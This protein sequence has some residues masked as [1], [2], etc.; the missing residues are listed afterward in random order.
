MS[1]VHVVVALGLLCTLPVLRSWLREKRERAAVGRVFRYGRLLTPELKEKRWR[2]LQGYEGQAIVSANHV[3][4]LLAA[5]LP[6]ES[7]QIVALLVPMEEPLDTIS[8]LKPWFE[9]EYFRTFLLVLNSTS[10]CRASHY[11]FL[12]DE[13]D[14]RGLHTLSDLF[15]TK[16]E[17]RQT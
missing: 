10:G 7:E 8:S 6:Q 15:W 16:D 17:R 11:A 13:D 1:A 9:I 2:C 3:G 14:E 5:P 12:V 4:V